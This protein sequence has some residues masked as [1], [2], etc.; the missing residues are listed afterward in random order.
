MNLFE[1]N[2]TYR[3]LE[4]REEDRFVVDSPEKADWALYKLR[5]VNKTIKQNKKLA[6]KNHEHIDEWLEHENS[7]ANDS[8]EYFESLLQEYFTNEKAKNPNFKFSSPNGTLSSRKQQDNWIYEESKLIDSLKN[9]EFVTNVP[10]LEKG[11]FKK[12]ANK[13]LD[14]LSVVGNKVVNTNT[15]EVIN[16]VQVQKRPDKIVISTEDW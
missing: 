2:Q 11:L 15:G 3:D 9:T 5:E 10:K 7:K 13:G 8:K 6:D 4:E 12:A 1:L 16:G 14:G